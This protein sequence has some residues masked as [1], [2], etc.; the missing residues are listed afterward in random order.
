M[1][2]KYSNLVEEI[3]KQEEVKEEKVNFDNA[4]QLLKE[5]IS[6]LQDKV[7]IVNQFVPDEQVKDYFNACD[8]VVQPYKSATQSGVTQVAYHFEKPMLVTNVGGLEEIVPNGIVG[9]AVNPNPLSI[10]DALNDFFSNHRM[11]EFEVHIV[12]E[13]KK[14]SWTRMIETIMSVHN[15]CNTKSD[16]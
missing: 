9:Y 4:L 16:K 13:K 11:P 15:A 8:I 7:I 2:T 5:A 6:G 3:D 10:A 14:Y 12:E 1:K